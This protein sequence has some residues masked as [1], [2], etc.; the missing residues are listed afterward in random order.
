MARIRET[1]NG[2]DAVAHAWSRQDQ[3]H[4]READKRGGRIFF[5]GPTI[6][7]YGRHFPIA[8]FY[9]RKGKEKIVLFT[10]RSYS[11]TTSAHMGAARGAV[12]HFRIIYCESPTDAEN[13]IH[14][15]NMRHWETSAQALANRLAKATK[16]EKYLHQIARIRANMMEY[17]EY[18]GISK[19]YYQA[20]GG[21]KT[22]FRYILIESKEAGTKATAKEIAARK[23][24]DAEQAKAR[25]KREAEALEAFR[26]GESDHV[27]D[28]D[29][30]YLRLRL[31]P[32]G[33]VVE[34]SNGITIPLEEAREYF[35]RLQSIRAKCK[36]S[37]EYNLFGAPEGMKFQGYAL[38]SA[39]PVY[40]EI[41]CHKITWGELESLANA[42][43]FVKEF[44][45]KEG[46]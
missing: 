11:N 31:I 4:G 24:Y 29:W 18:F 44:A 16:P 17:A 5:E 7:S 35:F 45:A 28:S 27:W 37:Q 33:Q 19:V 10:L 2:K 43:G 23:K 14:G 3:E 13:G 42:V 34:T 12:S 32:G 26:K 25:A 30:T 36:N 38:R 39:G 46:A 6:Y 9:Q 22:K 1:F 40:F 20:T 15:D 21:R 8:T 41:G